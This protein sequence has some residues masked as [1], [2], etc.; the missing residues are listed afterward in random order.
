M[1]GRPQG[2]SVLMATNRTKFDLCP[3]NR[4]QKLTPAE[5]KKPST[6]VVHSG[7]FANGCEDEEGSRVDEVEIVEANAARIEK[8]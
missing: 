6:A 7:P 2:A 3:K 5:T 1:S 8:V 4:P